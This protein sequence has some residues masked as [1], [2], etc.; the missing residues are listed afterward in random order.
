MQARHSLHPGHSVRRTLQLAAIG[1]ACAA[2]VAGCSRSK[3]PS[4]APRPPA[5][6]PAA[7]SPSDQA[8]DAV[9]AYMR[10]LQDGD[11]AA[12]YALLSAESRKRH[13]REE[14]ERMAKQGVTL[15]DLSSAR[16][17]L[18]KPDRA[19]VTLRLEEDPVSATIVAVKQDGKWYV[20]YARGRPGFP[21]PS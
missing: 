11:Y 15:Y 21:Y 3:P 20:V 18:V 19:E 4:V 8:R 13:P 9:V 10:Y 12:A 14:F 1:L 7:A 17:A 5:P 16:A 6:G 2:V